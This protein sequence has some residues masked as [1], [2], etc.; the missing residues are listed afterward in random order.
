MIKNA[1][2]PQTGDLLDLLSGLDMN[3]GSQPNPPASNPSEQKNALDFFNNDDAGGAL[4]S[5]AA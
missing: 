2:A 1:P 4:G 3:A 5:A